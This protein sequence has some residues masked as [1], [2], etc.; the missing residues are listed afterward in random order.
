MSTVV[1][2]AAQYKAASLKAAQTRAK[3]T[4]A[5]AE[6]KRLEK[7]YEQDTMSLNQAK[8]LLL[9]EAAS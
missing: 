4:A 2:V 8:R 1:G 5:Q 3:L 7:E 9:E 6:V